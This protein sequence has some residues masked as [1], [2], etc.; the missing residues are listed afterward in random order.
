MAFGLDVFESRETRAMIADG[1]DVQ[2]IPLAEGFDYILTSR[3]GI[4]SEC[5]KR[6]PR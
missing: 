6:W 3:S 1:D 5:P 2:Y 4:L